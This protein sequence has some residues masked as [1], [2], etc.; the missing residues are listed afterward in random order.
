MTTVFTE[1]HVVTLRMTVDIFTLRRRGGMWNIKITY[2]T[3]KEKR[4]CATDGNNGNDKK[5][6]FQ[7]RP[8]GGPDWSNRKS[9]SC[10]YRKGSNAGEKSGKWKNSIM[11][12]FKTSWKITVPRR[13]NNW[14]KLLPSKDSKNTQ[15]ANAA[16]TTWKPRAWQFGWRESNTL[17][18]STNAETK[19][20]TRDSARTGRKYCKYLQHNSDR[21]KNPLH[22]MKNA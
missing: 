3:T 12:A 5:G 17:P 15:Y 20:R 11:R 22:L 10:T 14:S 7:S 18:C 19:F 16:Y 4:N 1:H 8:R 9:N 6:I 21:N 13:E 2:R